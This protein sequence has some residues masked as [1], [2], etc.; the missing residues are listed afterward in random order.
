MPELPPLRRSTGVHEE[1]FCAI[2]AHRQTTYRVD[3][4]ERRQMDEKASAVWTSMVPQSRNR[5][6]G[7]EP[8]PSKPSVPV[9]RYTHPYRTT[10]SPASRSRPLVHCLH[11][12]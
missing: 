12:A 2:S 9:V 5:L 8:G 1:T 11:H 10:S 7:E 3:W 6:C 4:Q